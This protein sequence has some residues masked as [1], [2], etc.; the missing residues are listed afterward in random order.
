[1]NEFRIP[2]QLLFGQ[3]P[4]G[5]SVGSPLL[6]FKDK[7]KDNLKQC[8]IPF[9]SLENKALEHRTWCQSCFSSLQKF[10]QSQLQY[11]DQL[12]ANMRERWQ[13]VA[14]LNGNLL[15]W[16]FDMKQSRSCCLLRKTHSK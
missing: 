6:H 10:E 7:L 15:L 8:K 3:F 2:K 13:N 11:R 12:C 16:F 9:S 1:M 4:T 14:T 5:R